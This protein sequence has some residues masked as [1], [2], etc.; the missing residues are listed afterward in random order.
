MHIV[1]VDPRDQRTTSDSSTRRTL[2]LRGPSRRTL[3]RFG[4]PSRRTLGK[5]SPSRRTL[6]RQGAPSRR[7][8]G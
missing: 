7:L 3:G 8:A 1:P 4:A 5:N 6:G 2:A